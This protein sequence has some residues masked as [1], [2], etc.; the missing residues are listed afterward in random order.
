[1]PSQGSWGGFF[2]DRGGKLF[3]MATLMPFNGRGMIVNK[4][5]LAT[6]VSDDTGMT[7]ADSAKAVDAVFDAI[8]AALKNGDDCRIIGFG[9]FEVS[10]RAAREGRDPRTRKPLQIKATNVPK[11]KAGKALKEAVN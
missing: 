1:M 7:K 8:T 6:A 2:F 5:E 11:F 3:L 10:H 4:N 9:N